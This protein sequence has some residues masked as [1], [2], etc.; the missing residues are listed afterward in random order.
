MNKGKRQKSWKRLVAAILIAA[1]TA[2]SIPWDGETAQA[3]ETQETK[4][5]ALQENAGTDAA[6]EMQPEE[7]GPAADTYQ[8][9]EEDA[10]FGENTETSTTFDVGNDKKMTV[11]YEEA[12][13]YRDEDG[14]LIDYDP[15]LTEV[16]QETSG[17]GEELE[18]YAYEN[19]EGDK[20]HYFPDELTDETPILLE[21]EGYALS[22]NPAEEL[23]EVQVEEEEYTNGY[24]DT[25]EVPL[26]AVYESEQNPVSYE[27]TSMS[28]GVK[29]EIVLKERPEGNQFSYDLRLTG[30]SA[31]KNQLDEGI[32]LYDSHTEEIVGC[33]SPPNMNDATGEAYSEA[34][35]CEV[36]ADGAEEG[37]YHVT[38]TAGQ[39]YLDAPGRM[40]PVTID[41]TATW[42]GKA[43]VGDVYVLSGT[44][45]KGINFYD[46]GVKVI[47]AGKGSKGVYRTYLKFVDL[48][49]KIKGYYVDSAVL[50]LYETA[51][52]GS[53]QTVQAYRVKESWTCGKV[54]WNNRPGYD[55]LY[56]TVKSTGKYK[57]ERKLA[58]TAFAR[59]IANSSFPN[60]GIMLKGASESG[61]YCEF[62]GSRHGT[63]SLR[64][65]LS[66]V[67][68]D[69]PTTPAALTVSPQFVKRGTQARAAWS[70]ISSKSLAYVQYRL[71]RCNASGAETGAA[72][73]YSASTKLG[74][75]GSGSAAIAASSGWG[76]GIYKLAVRGVDNG[77]IA[78]GERGCIFYIDGTPPAMNQ[79]TVTPATTAEAP[80]DDMTP[81][82]AWS[83]ASDAYFKQVECRVDGGAFKAVGTGASG[84]YKLPE[85]TLAGNGE[86]TIVLRA[87]DKAG[88]EKSYTLKYYLN[89]KGLGFGGTLP[90][91]ESL[92]IR[93]EYGKNILS[94]RSE[95]TLTD[96]VYY[97][98]YRGEQEDFAADE[99]SMA[100][101]KIKEMHWADIGSGAGKKYY[102]RLE[103]VRTDAAGNI[104]DAVLLDTVLSA[105]AEDAGEYQKRTGVRDYMGYYEFATPT[106]SGMI[107]NSSGNLGY[108]QE[109]AQ[110]PA[111]QLSFD[112]TRN[113]NSQSG[114]TGMC[115]KGW[116]DS[117]H[118]EL[119]MDETGR[120]R[121]LDS[122]GTVYTFEKGMD[123]YRCAETKDFTLQSAETALPLTARVM[124][125]FL[126]ADGAESSGGAK[127]ASAEN[128]GEAELDS[129]FI[130]TSVYTVK[131]HGNLGSMGKPDEPGDGD[132]KEET[133]TQAHAYTVKT[134]DG[135]LYRF[136]EGGRLTA[137]VEP[138]GTFLLYR[139]QEDGRLRSVQT[140]AGNGIVLYY[141]E[142]S[143]LLKEITLPDFTSVSYAYED[144]R[145]T[146]ISRLSMDK[147]ESTGFQYG[148]TEGKLSSVTDGKGQAY[149]VSYQGEKAEKVTYPNKESYLLDFQNG[150][151]SV[152]KKN[153]SGT[154]I[155]TTSA[156]YEPQSGKTLKETDADGGTTS[157]EYGFDGNPY[158][159]T[160]TKKT[161]GYETITDGKV[162]IKT[163]EKVTETAYNAD[164]NVKSEKAEDGTVTTYKY[165]TTSE[166][167]ADSPKVV[168]AELNGTPLSKETTEYDAKGN[169]LKET[170][171][172]D[173]ANK[174]VTVN[175]YD[176]SGNILESIV[177][178]DGLEVSKSV[179]TYDDDGNILHEKEVSAD[180][181]SE[182]K[183]TYDPMGRPLKS[184]DEST[185]Q[186]TEYT[187]DYLGRTTKTAVTLN[188]KTQ[189]STS[190]YDGNGTVI[191]ETDTAGITNEYR[192][193]AINRIVERKVT[194]GDTITYK[195][196]Y[197][198]GDVTIQDGI[199]ERTVKNAYIEKESYP[200]GTTSSEKYYD[201]DGKVVREK[202]GGLYT[203]YTYDESG[204]QVAAYSNGTEAGKADGKVTLTLYNEKGIQTAAIVNPSVE[205]G[206]YAIGKDTIVTKQQHD[207]KGNVIKETDPKGVVTEYA[208]DDS[209]RVTQVIQ[210]AEGGKLTTKAEYTTDAAG[211]TTSTT[212]TDAK[213]H[214]SVEVKDAA[215]LIRSTTDHGDSAQESIA[216]AYEYDS[217]GNQTKATYENDAYKTFTY[218]DRNLLTT[219]KMYGSDGKQQLQTD[220]TYDDQYRQTK[221][222]DSRMK[223]GSLMPYRYT[224]TGY[225]GFGRTAWSA[226]VDAESE[227]TEDQ[228]SAHKIT[229]TYDAEDKVTGVRYALV[230]DGGVAGLEYAYDGNRWLTDVRAV[231]K[232]RDDKLLIREYAYDPQGK[233]SEVKEY[234]GFL[235]TAVPGE[236]AG[237]ENES[238]GT[239]TPAG[240]GESTCIT[241]T[242]SY[243]KLDRVTAMVYKKGSEVLES[244]TYK[245]D[246]NSQLTEK[247]EVNNTPKTEHDKVNITKAYTYNALG[248]L[249]KTEVTDHKDGDKKETVTYEYDKAGNRIKKAEGNAQTTY[250]YN[251]LDQ[252]L[253]AVTGRDGEKE[254]TVSYEYDV[255]GNQVKESDS[256]SQATTVNEYDAENR[257]SKAVITMPE[258]EALPGDVAKPEMEQTSEVAGT[259]TTESRNR[260]KTITQENLYNG[261]GQRVRKSE[262]AKE[263]HYFYQDGVVSYTVEG[264]K[265]T[266]AVQNLLGLEGNVIL[267]ERA[268]EISGE[269]TSEGGI[270]GE[271]SEDG[272]AFEETK[273]RN[274][275]YYL[276][277]KD[278]QGSTTSILDEDGAG[279]LSYEYDDFGETE[280][281]GNSAFRNEICYTGGIYDETM[282]L[283]YLNAR[284]YDPE[285]GRFL[286]EDTYRGEL[287]E[288]DTLHLYVY[289]K[290]NPIN[291][292]DPS[293]HW[294]LALAGAGY[295]YIVG[296]GAMA[297]GTGTAI[298]VGGS[299]FIVTGIVIAGIYHLN[300]KGIKVRLKKSK[301]KAKAT[302]PKSG[303]AIKHKISQR[304]SKVEEEEEIIPVGGHRTTANGRGRKEKH[305]KGE[306]RRKREQGGDKKRKKKNWKDRSNKKK[307]KK[308]G[309]KK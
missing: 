23:R 239:Q 177:T 134:K 49:T 227:P 197:S 46:S 37:L 126:A 249:A 148:Y 294:Q 60:Y 169:A 146:E 205:N 5:N 63:S 286:T 14:K 65:K 237:A 16:S 289:C 278:V 100:A 172:T 133:V 164:E 296:S 280:I 8:V 253:T 69:K 180:V 166:W 230:K 61:H 188:G 204:N 121:F 283:Y 231:I 190:S 308:S 225:D 236:T 42:T 195:T 125:S 234:P 129:K 32:T 302:I 163:E 2:T 20:K 131:N 13:R 260:I 199:K 132:G 268:V 182:E 295:G 29:E 71:A 212:I 162:E 86:H 9:S 254:R 241:K 175:V 232:G 89:K 248:Q 176:D 119:V 141:E 154:D 19:T 207:D 38:V 41:P 198:Y 291:Y 216:T 210:D 300:K 222:V 259:D 73:N 26:K 192:Y 31:R 299:I 79:P 1:F 213:G 245:Y 62:V 189:T 21:N 217:K 264:K 165:D 17:N 82:I 306:E 271:K 206:S 45:Y 33:I 85:G 282:G 77:G 178:E 116:T 10:R 107:E 187:Y 233:V 284:Y 94:W 147:K 250:T 74:T 223:D 53:G 235:R 72:V 110:I 150:K 97:R 307:S 301:V 140:E 285:N 252:L 106:G 246:K 135:T 297:V 305:E 181:V 12:V 78:G 196:D 115:G 240:A 171:A 155:Y 22:M 270:S 130:G 70:G 174:T 96:N 290:N 277:N 4:Q 120:V 40:Y 226:E 57:S 191:K 170:D 93:R 149:S 80:S 224:Y 118:K 7:E 168:D 24:E 50:T 90:Q 102:Y 229:Y 256:K 47:N 158:L 220:Y 88:N 184:T 242:Y 52:S 122:D 105:E 257:L 98:V 293:G 211:G 202:A 173:A 113:Y 151:T 117:L 35:T 123:G 244:Y 67:Y 27:Y 104:E 51:N 292:V 95:S 273:N 258:P 108:S 15:A 269:P 36:T 28:S 183:N 153:E 3:Q 255:N 208:Y 30:M 185:G 221:M 144:G 309:K 200:D 179:Y 92:K 209:G 11:F 136:D 101:D 203:D 275:D 303:K 276:Y 18:G 161:I 39:E 304:K 83:G 145:L 48:T 265:E 127:A 298:V 228:V 159:V 25:A 156:E 138:N 288:P 64:P 279:E 87:V 103:A 142:E 266:K 214:T 75:A 152:T 55:T 143:G 43:N 109:D 243:D 137:A 114:L 34:L 281:N 219:A 201:K 287:K 91:E 247:T 218:D 56:S 112:V 193:D 44:K 160:K 215:G 274:F 54:T 167:T 139:Y 262:G 68:Y 263:T 267:A 128:V 58:L 261:D 84:T 238:A 194:K 6:G 81:V 124:R 272:V 66:V 59:G 99:A 186:V 111:G 157:Y 251:G 76:D